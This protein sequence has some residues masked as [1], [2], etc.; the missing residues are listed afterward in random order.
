MLKKLGIYSG[1][2]DKLKGNL[3]I[4]IKKVI[5]KIGAHYAGVTRG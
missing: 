5:I 1:G 4:T 3:C 2:S